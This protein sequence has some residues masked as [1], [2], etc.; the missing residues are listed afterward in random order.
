MSKLFLPNQ[1]NK[2]VLGM[3]CE[4][5]KVGCSQAGVYKFFSATE[6]FYL[7]V[8]PKTGDLETE[9]NNM[10]W[11]KGKI[12]VPR[13]IEWDSDK[14]AD[15]LLISDIGGKML[16]DDFYLKN[17][18]LAV[19]LLAKGI[20]LLRTVDIKDCPIH[21]DLHKKLK[22][23]TENIRL[24]RV[25]MTDWES[26]SNGFSSPED[27]LKYLNSNIPKNEELVFTHGDYCLPNI[28]ADKEQLTGF[29]DIGRA[30]AADLWQDVALCI[31]SLRHN[32]KTEDYDD[33]LLKQIG[34]PINKEKLNYYIL[35]DELF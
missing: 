18:A 17:P 19:S 26:S 23:A 21:N 1:I 8:E 30:G 32:F 25:D 15:Y 22:N 2:H 7:K 33:L 3:E 6:V 34:I 13:I 29:I 27:L 9:Y 12:S 35:L 14:D 10:L 28:F 24:N 5:N 11:L 4:Q 16:C 31:R 20:N